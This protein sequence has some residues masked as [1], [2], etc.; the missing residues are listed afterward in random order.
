MLYVIKFGVIST[1][2]MTDGRLAH[3]IP[4]IGEQPKSQANDDLWKI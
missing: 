2:V 3:L 4:A 1:F